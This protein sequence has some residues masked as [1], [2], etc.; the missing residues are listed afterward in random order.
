MAIFRELFVA[1]V[2][3]S[4]EVSADSDIRYM[5]GAKFF[6]CLDLEEN[7]SFHDG[8]SLEKNYFFIKF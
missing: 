7:P 5:P 1:L 4:S 2:V 8:N 3:L 6:A